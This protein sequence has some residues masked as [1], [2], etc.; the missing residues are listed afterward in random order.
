MA[1]ILIRSTSRRKT[2]KLRKMTTHGDV[3]EVSRRQWFCHGVFTRPRAEATQVG[4]WTH[5]FP[6]I[7]EFEELVSNAV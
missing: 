7:H 5:F 6:R 4:G 3:A 2:V 1:G